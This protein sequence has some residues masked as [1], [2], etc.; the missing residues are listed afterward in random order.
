M[1]Q[2]T[3]LQLR[4]AKIIRRMAEIRR[5]RLVKRYRNQTTR[6]RHF[7]ENSDGENQVARA[8]EPFFQAQIKDVASRLREVGGKAT[9]RDLEKDRDW[10]E[11]H[12][13]GQ[14]SQLT[15]GRGSSRGYTIDTGGMDREELQDA[16][17]IVAGTRSFE[18]VGK[19]VGAP[20]GS[21]LSVGQDS[22]GGITVNV[23]HED[24]AWMSRTIDKDSKGN[25]RIYNSELEVKKHA[26]GKGIGTQILA[27]QVEF[28]S[29]LGA[30]Y[31][32][33]V[34]V[35]NKASDLNG[36][37]T[38]ASNGKKLMTIPFDENPYSALAVWFKT[39]EGVE[40]YKSIQKK[41]K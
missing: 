22:S 12:L 6:D 28:G 9:G 23:E 17:E 34:A 39:D 5:G 8:L 31:I 15:H 3:L 27:D 19:A 38:W 41:L 18:N 7:K 29:K 30:K 16:M 33:T 20:A 36:G 21:V 10:F 14:H 35:T 37:Y 25:L 26:R 13:P 40:V 32:E 2:A 1:E 11:K 4:A 24:I